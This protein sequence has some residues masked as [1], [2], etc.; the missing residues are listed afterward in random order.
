VSSMKKCLDV[1]MTCYVPEDA[2]PTKIGKMKDNGAS[3]VNMPGGRKECEVEAR[4][5]A[6]E[7]D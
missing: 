3:I 2:S 5:V 4:R 1:P 6:A 7:N